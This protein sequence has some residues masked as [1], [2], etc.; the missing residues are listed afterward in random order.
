MELKLSIITVNFNNKQ[1]LKA[2][3]ESIEKQTFSSYE[4]IIIDA[5]STDGSKETIEQYAANNPRVTFW[6]S[7]HDNGIYD[8]M[9]KGIDHAQGEYLYFLNSGDT[10]YEDVLNKILFDGTKYIYGDVRVSLTKEKIVDIKSPFPLDLIFIILKDTI[11]HQVCFIHR[12][13]F[14]NQRYRTDYIL[15]SDWI[16]IVDNI[17]L[18]GCSYK[19]IPI[20]IADHDGNGISATSGTLGVD[21]RT[22]WIKENIPQAFYDILLE[23]DEKRIELQELKNS[24]LG[25]IIPK[26]RHS[27]KF[28]KRMAKFILFLYKIKCMF[29]F[30]SHQNNLSK[31]E[32]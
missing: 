9:N 11:C 18:K 12:S 10:L 24:N 23:L 8:G 3:I 2:T 1:G 19:H 5:G 17:I 26:M 7:E 27:K 21:E 32:L 16:H 30:H 28:T 20:Y 15:A 6:V 29:S 25:K 22:R 13:L 31:K 14:Y 4:H